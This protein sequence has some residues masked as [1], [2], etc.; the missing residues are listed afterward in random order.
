M[1]LEEGREDEGDALPGADPNDA[2]AP[3]LGTVKVTETPEMG[4]L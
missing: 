3:L 1:L 2:L 4:L